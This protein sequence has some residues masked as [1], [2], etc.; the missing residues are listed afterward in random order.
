MHSIL[1]GVLPVDGQ[2]LSVGVGFFYRKPF[3]FDFTNSVGGVPV[4]T[5][6]FKI[7]DQ[8]KRLQQR[9]FV[10]LCSVIH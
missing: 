3:A 5:S 10:D 8:R 2:C 4:D 1:L 6:V 7:V 9:S